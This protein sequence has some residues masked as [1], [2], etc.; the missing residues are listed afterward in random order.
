MLISSLAYF[1]SAIMF[2]NTAPPPI[3]ADENSTIEPIADN[4][5]EVITVTASKRAKSVQEIPIAVDVLNNEDIIDLGVIDLEN[6]L[7][8]FPNLSSNATTELAVGYSIRGIGTNNPHGNISQA[9]GI[10][11]DEVSY[12]SPYSG[13]LG[14]YDT[15]RIE[16]LRGPQNTFFGRNTIGGAVHYISA[17]PVVGDDHITGSILADVGRFNQFNLTAVMNIPLGDHFA[18]RVAG[19]SAQQDGIYTN[20]ATNSSGEA[21]GESTLGNKERQSG[22]MQLSWDPTDSTSILANYHYTKHDGTN[23]GNRAFGT[24]DASDPYLLINGAQDYI[25]SSVPDDRASISPWIDMVD[26]NNTDIINSVDRNGFNP[27][28]GDWHK[29]YNVSSAKSSASVS[30]GFMKFVHQFDNNHSVYWRSSFDE[31]DIQTSDETSGTN[32]LQF[33]PNRDALYEQQAHEFRVL[34]PDNEP[35]RWLVGLYYFKEDMELFTIVRRFNYIGSQGNVP[36]DVAAH[37]ILFQEDKDLS[38]YGNVEWDLSEKLTLSSGLRYTENT[39]QANS[40]FGVA[41]NY[42]TNPSGGGSISSMPF[43][44]SADLIF[45]S[46]PTDTFLGKTFLDNCYS[47]VFDDCTVLPPTIKEYALEQELSEWGGRVALDYQQTKDILLYGSYARGFKSGGFDTRALAAFFGEG[48]EQA[49]LPEYVDTVELGIKTQ[50]T[51]SLQINSAIFYNLWQDLQTFG[52]FEG[53]PRYVNIP[54]ATT[55]GLESEIKW[56]PEAT[57]F[58]QIGI[59]LLDT[60]ITDNGDLTAADEGHVLPNSPSFTLNGLLRKQIELAG[61]VLVLQSDARYVSE[62]ID[63]L[64]Y[65]S[66]R[67]ATKDA[68]FWINARANYQFGTEYQYNIAL[69]VEN[70]TEETYCVDIGMQNI[71]TPT[72][73]AD[74][75]PRGIDLTS[76]ISCQPSAASGERFFGMSVGVNFN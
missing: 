15:E 33:I 51:S 67:F 19:Q 72:T 55:K 12:G 70:I 45:D 35:L 34:S 16:V 4:E 44:T 23:I 42:N 17:K 76:T 32:S 10:F 54:Q 30:G 11:R 29:I 36:R 74:I 48:A 3:I 59:G 56:I 6:I 13:I 63:G 73:E 24:R 66:D 60:E 57:W 69:W 46:V 37:N 47:E 21:L 61:G 14:V 43:N 25:D 1:Y 8:Q 7:T 62:Q 31:T 49:F 39:K 64:T 18:L 22:R 26:A 20:L 71:I 28:T 9:V 52:V 58:T 5:I 68:Q 41:A 75:G 2:A 50:L 27:A 65:E 40:R 53:E 38:L